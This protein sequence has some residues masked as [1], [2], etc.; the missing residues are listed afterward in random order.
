MSNYHCFLITLLYG[1]ELVKCA[2][3]VSVDDLP[4]DCIE[5]PLEPENR[6]LLHALLPSHVR[7]MGMV[8]AVEDILD[9]VAP[10]K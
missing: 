7:E 9:I 4:G 5:Y 6:G 10:D 1:S 3:R 2:L 8:V